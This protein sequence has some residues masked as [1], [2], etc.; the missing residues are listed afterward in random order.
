[1]PTFGIL[2]TH[3]QVAGF[4][5][6]KA[7]LQSQGSTLAKIKLKNVGFKQFG[8]VLKIILSELEAVIFFS[9]V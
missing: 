7:T 3:N 2:L 8:S 5:L 6:I 9:E 1:M 4:I